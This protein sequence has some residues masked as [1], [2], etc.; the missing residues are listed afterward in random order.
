[1]LAERSEQNASI[2][3][4]IRGGIP[5]ACSL[6]SSRSLHTPLYAPLTSKLIKLRTFLDLHAL[7][8]HSWSSNRACSADRCFLPPKWFAGSKPNVTARYEI[9]SATTDSSIF[10]SVGNRDIGLQAFAM[11]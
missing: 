3:R 10:P 4:T 11:V 7:Y 6:C 5:R 8:M 2:Q 1:M 9:R